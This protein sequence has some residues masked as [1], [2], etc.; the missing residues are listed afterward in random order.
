MI[1]STAFN[2][3][4][5]PHFALSTH[6]VTFPTF[7]TDGGKKIPNLVNLICQTRNYLTDMHFCTVDQTP[8]RICHWQWGHLFFTSIFDKHSR[9]RLDFLYHV[10]FK[11]FIV[12]RS[13][14]PI[15]VLIPGTRIF[16]DCTV[17]HCIWTWCIYICV[18]NKQSIT[19]NINKQSTNTT[20]TYSLNICKSSNWHL[21]PWI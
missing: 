5:L 15:H 13:R 2:N 7:I 16:H 18:T 11:I 21:N 1:L 19:C 8:G 10:L 6:C 17:L 12:S 20:Q 9:L 14:L 3:P 4:A